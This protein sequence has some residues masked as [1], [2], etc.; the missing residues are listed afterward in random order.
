L[1]LSSNSIY[2]HALLSDT[3]LH[4]RNM[5][6]SDRNIASKSTHTQRLQ[7]YI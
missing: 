6:T 2:H 5:F 4:G 3:R 7:A 1:N